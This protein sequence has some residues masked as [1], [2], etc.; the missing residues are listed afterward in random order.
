MLCADPDDHVTVRPILIPTHF[1]AFQYGLIHM[2]HITF[3]EILY[4]PVH[5]SFSIDLGRTDH[6]AGHDTPAEVE[7]SSLPVLF[8]SVKRQ[9]HDCFL[10]YDVGHKRRRRHRILQKRC[11][12]AGS[13]DHHRLS[14]LIFTTFGA[15]IIMI[16]FHFDIEALRNVFDGPVYSRFQLLHGCATYRAHRVL[17]CIR[18]HIDDLFRKRLCFLLHGSALFGGRRSL[19]AHSFQDS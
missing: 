6:P 4:H 18:I 5:Q 15:D 12:F 10:G 11:F 9:S 2:D 8:L 16:H 3:P 13:R 19:F 14:I 17:A 7:S 1:Q